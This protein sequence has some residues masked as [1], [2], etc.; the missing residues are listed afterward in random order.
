M[1]FAVERCCASTLLETWIA[2][3]F[4]GMVALGPT[5]ESWVRL[6]LRPLPDIVLF[7]IRTLFV[8]MTL[9]P[10]LSLP[11]T[12]LLA[13]RAPEQVSTSTPYQPLPV[14]SLLKMRMFEED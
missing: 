14:V 5:R 9:I 13:I 7:Q 1:P 8:S 10:S 3:S 6:M 2:P 11:T 4:Q 12:R